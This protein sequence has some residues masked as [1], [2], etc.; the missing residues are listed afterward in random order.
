MK[1]MCY[2][3][4]IIAFLMFYQRE[5]IFTIIIIGIVA[6]LYLF[7]RSRKSSSRR[8]RGGFFSSITGRT[9]DRYERNIDEIITLM[10]LQQLFSEKSSQPKN[11]N[12]TTNKNSEY[13]KLEKI[14]EDIL[15]LLPEE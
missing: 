14:K 12:L 2:I 11:D 6:G 9:D 4:L 8:R 7:F 15:A 1:G 5:P 13:A 3:V 10:M